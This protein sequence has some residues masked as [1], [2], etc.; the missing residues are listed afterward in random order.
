LAALR[1]ALEVT[2]RYAINGCGYATSRSFWAS[3]RLWSFL[4]D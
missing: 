2:K 3:A 4:S 1:E